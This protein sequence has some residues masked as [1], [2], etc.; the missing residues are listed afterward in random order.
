M[1]KKRGMTVKT[2]AYLIMAHQH[3]D[4]LGRLV[5]ALDSA[6]AGFYIH[7]DRRAAGFDEQKLRQGV[8]GQIH[9]YRRYA[10]TWGADSQIRAEQL[11]LENAV[12]DGYDWY[13]LLSGVD[14]PLKPRTQIEAFFE[15]RSESFLQ[16]R[17]GENA[18]ETMER[19]QY[20]YPLQGKI[21]R[22]RANGG[23]AYGALQQLSYECIKLQRALGVDR[24]KNAPFAYVRGANWFSITHE[25]AA[26][27]VGKRK[28][29]A[30][31]FYHSLN[32]DEMFVQCLAAASPYPV[33]N[34]CLR[35]IDWQRTEHDGCSPHT[36]TMADWAILEASDKLFAR[37]FDPAVD[38]DVIDALYRRIEG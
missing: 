28:E 22:P 25:L 6:S 30:R 36:F 1:R 10:V 24:T 12:K 26:Y 11:L 21:G 38:A 31:Y 29:I 32:A 33:V 18:P 9:V 23:L 17:P 2:H 19:V 27:V 3:F 16:I 14:I 4:L 5:R 7:I 15:N 34:D 35:L 8:R 13:H 20:Y 37:K